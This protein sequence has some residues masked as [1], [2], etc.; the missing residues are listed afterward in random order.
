MNTTIRLRNYII[1]ALLV[2]CMPAA[3]QYFKL[4]AQT[5][6]QVQ[7]AEAALQTMTPDQIDAKIKEM[8][9]SRAEAEAKAKEYGIDLQSYLMKGNSAAQ[10]AQPTV[11]I[12]VD[13]KS[14][15]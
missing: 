6:A 2:C 5:Q 3:S 8:G 14:V 13:R 9:M 12:N 7:K 4:Q 1:F 15:V 10:Q 11:N